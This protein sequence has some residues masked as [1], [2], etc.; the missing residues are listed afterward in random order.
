MIAGLSLCA[1]RIAGAQEPLTEAAV[2]AAR[3]ASNAA[4]ARRDTIALEAMVSA[5]YHSVSSRNAHTNGRAE[6][7][8]QWNQQFTAHADVS[9]VRTPTAVRLFA[10]WE[11][12]EETGTW[13]GRWTEPDG[14]VEIRGGYAAK[15]RRIN[16]R[17]LLEAEVFTPRWCT[18]SAYCTRPP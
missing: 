16:G 3:A 13:V 10:P 11:M 5:L 12:A 4:I 6:V 2:R 1:A 8:R 18:G 14:R 7:R 9:Y 17:W 15:W